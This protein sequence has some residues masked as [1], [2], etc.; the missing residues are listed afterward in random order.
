MA[1]ANRLFVDRAKILRHCISLKKQR[2]TTMEDH[3]DLFKC[4]IAYSV[5]HVFLIKHENFTILVSSNLI[6]IVTITM[7][8]LLIIVRN[9]LYYT[10]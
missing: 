5:N 8:Y 7:I 6:L 9:A 4:V 2:N 10:I 1:K 3:C